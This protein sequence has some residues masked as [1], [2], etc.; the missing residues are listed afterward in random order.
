MPPTHLAP[1]A[2]PSIERYLTFPEREDIAIEVGKGTG[3]NAIAR[4]PE[5]SPRTI[6]RELK[7]NAEAFARELPP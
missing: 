1:S 6:S 5:R 2:T 3:I 7:L 4:K